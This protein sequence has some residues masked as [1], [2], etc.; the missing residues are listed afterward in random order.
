MREIEF[1]IRYRDKSWYYG[2]PLTKIK[3]DTVGFQ[4]FDGNYYDLF[5][6]ATTLG[7]Y[8]G[9]K[10]KNGTKIFEG[11]IIKLTRT[12]MYAPTTSFHNQDLVSLH[13]VYWND[14]KHCFYHEHFDLERKRVTGGGSL[15]FNDERAKQNI[16]EVI[17][18]IY[19]NPELWEVSNG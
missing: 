11:D 5:A 7:Q 14:D 16:I 3:N 18:N 9:L 19:N 6:D 10:D 13:R 2:V 4:S 12:N 15:N 17:G 8:T 1:R